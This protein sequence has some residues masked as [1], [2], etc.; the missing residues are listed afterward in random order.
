MK[1]RSIVI[2][3]FLGIKSYTAGIAGK[4][5]RF[6]ARNGLGKSTLNNAVLWCLFGKD[7]ENRDLDPKPRD[8]GGKG[9]RI[10]GAIPSVEITFTGEAGEEIV[11]ERKL[12][13]DF[14]DK[15]TS[16]PI[17][18]GD[19]T[20]TFVNGVS[21]GTLAK[22]GKRV[23]EVTGSPDIFKV[24]L[25]PNSFLNNPKWE[26]RRAILEQMCGSLKP[27]DILNDSEIK[28]LNGRPLAEAVDIAKAMLKKEEERLDEAVIQHGEALRK[29]PENYTDPAG[30]QP[31]L[32]AIVKERMQEEERCKN[33]NFGKMTELT[34]KIASI[35]RKAMKDYADINDVHD[36]EINRIERKIREA[37]SI[38]ESNERTLKSL[39][40][41]IA[42]YTEKLAS[43]KDKYNTENDTVFNTD[44]CDKC[45]Q[46]LPDFLLKEYEEKFN[47]S[48]AEKLKEIRG[49]GTRVRDSLNEAEKSKNNA[50]IVINGNNEEI[51]ALEEA[52]FALRKKKNT[53]PYKDP[54]EIA[55]IESEIKELSEQ[56]EFKKSQE[57]YRLEGEEQ[58]LRDDIATARTSGDH[59][60]RA[61]ELSDRIETLGD[62]ITELKRVKNAILNI[63]RKWNKTI[64]EKVNPLFK[65]TKFRMIEEQK[66][67]DPRDVCEAMHEGIDYNRTLNTG[68]KV[69]MCVD[70]ANTFKKHF[71]LDFPTIIDNAESVTD[72]IV[73][74]SGQAIY[75]YADENS[76][77]LKME[78]I[79][80]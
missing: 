19:K 26:K 65:I 33:P 40:R 43:L 18:K 34:D 7:S 44:K 17:Y 15:K 16:K 24:I 39:E 77:K 67:G 73:R 31:K 74:P 55:K 22:Y 64:E 80:E 12:L 3:D 62:N 66:N 29:V 45:G 56:G 47:E 27:V 49:D 36:S 61:K 69:N 51:K 20:E 75:L 70:V 78:V 79:N 42:S 23:E 76:D 35:R 32:D 6:R 5:V 63:Q 1:I 48:K 21:T 4:S 25:D 14:A 71:G 30:L 54:A 8:R 9:E 10:M 53:E 59:A 50:K 37:K 60:R 28:Q 38:I 2:T 57:L 13:E 11:F 72:W 41:E 52:V 68:A 58:K 46:A